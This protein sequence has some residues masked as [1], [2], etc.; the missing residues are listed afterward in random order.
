MRMQPTATIPTSAKRK[1]LAQNQGSSLLV[2]F[3][4]S[5]VFPDHL[6]LSYKI[7]GRTDRL[8]VQLSD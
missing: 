2:P 7:A 8:L 1:A 3:I 6:S 4:L 5:G